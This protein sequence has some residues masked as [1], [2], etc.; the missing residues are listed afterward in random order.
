MEK[1]LQT[2][3]NILALA[4]LLADRHCRGTARFDDTPQGTT[5]LRSALFKKFQTKR[6]SGLK[7]LPFDPLLVEVR[8]IIL[9]TVE[10][11]RAD[12]LRRQKKERATHDSNAPSPTQESF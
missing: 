10:A 12:F 5:N 3:V 8:Q 2:K 9:S 11:R 1:E 6:W 4:G 7:K